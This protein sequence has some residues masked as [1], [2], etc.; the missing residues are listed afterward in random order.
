EVIGGDGG[1]REVTLRE[2]RITQAQLAADA[3]GPVQEE[4][5]RRP[6]IRD[7]AE[8]SQGLV[9]CAGAEMLVAAGDVRDRLGL[10]VEE[11]RAGFQDRLAQ[12]ARALEVHGEQAQPRFAETEEP[13]I[14]AVARRVLPAF[15]HDAQY[16]SEAPRAQERDGLPAQ[17]KEVD[18]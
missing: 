9:H 8:A 5:P 1:L 14:V 18:D 13:W 4:F 17:G 3:P 16:L 10:L 2:P 12:L 6:W 11:F 7:A 15:A